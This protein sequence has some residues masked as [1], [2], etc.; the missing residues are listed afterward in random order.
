MSLNTFASKYYNTLRLNK[1]FLFLVVTMFIAINSIAQSLEGD[2]STYDETQEKWTLGKKYNIFTQVKF[3]YGGILPTVEEM[4]IEKYYGLDLRL[5]WQKKENGVYSYLYK[6]P[7]FGLGFYSGSFDN[8]AFGEPNGLYGFMEVPIFDHR[9]KLNWVYTIG[10]GLAFNFNYFDPIENP[11]NELIGSSKNVYVAFSLEGR[12][13]IT[14]QW[15]AG[16]GFGFKHFSN[17]RVALPN[18]GINLLPLTVSTEYNFGNNYT[19]IKKGIPPSFIPY[20]IFNIYGATGFKNF[21]YGGAVYFKSTLGISFLRQFSYKLRYGLGTEIFYT[22]GS[23]NRVISDKSNFNKQISYG[24]SAQLEWILTERMYIPLNFGIH[25]NYNDENLEQF[26]YQRIGFGYLMGKNKKIILAI[27]L[28]V[29]EFHADYVEW[30]IG[31]SFKKD[32]NKYDL[33]F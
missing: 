18:R 21:E 15:V 8:N 19:D 23:L 31:Y 9:K 29:T 16:L 32:K 2:T 7:K 30:T 14:E 25:L 28:K 6:A 17:G 20:N 13:N 5:A 4:G 1:D 12:Y 11:S 26:L 27:N 3:D 10:L 22:A 33:I 24:I